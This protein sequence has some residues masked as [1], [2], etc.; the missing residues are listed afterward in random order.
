MSRLVNR[1]EELD[2]GSLDKS[3]SRMKASFVSHSE[4]KDLECGNFQ[5]RKINQAVPK[6][7]VKF[8]QSV[9][10]WGAMAACGVRQA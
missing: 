5:E 9:M 2:G 3:S 6:S 1:K 4:I 10:V 8:P 7:S